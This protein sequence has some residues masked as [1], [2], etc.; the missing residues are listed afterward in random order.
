VLAAIQLLIEAI[1]QSFEIHGGSN[2][3]PVP[4]GTTQAIL[5]EIE[6]VF[7]IARACMAA[8]RI[9]SS[10]MSSLLDTYC[11]ISR[12]MSSIGA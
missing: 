7:R 6:P 9:Y 8:E 2:A 10:E 11:R 5:Y 4:A 12:L 3:G 1:F